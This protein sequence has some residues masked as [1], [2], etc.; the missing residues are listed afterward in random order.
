M[1]KLKS[2]LFAFTVIGISFGCISG[3]DKDP[4]RSVSA[5]NLVRIMDEASIEAQ[6]GCVKPI[7]LDTCSLY[8]TDRYATGR[9]IFFNAVT[10]S[11][12]TESPCVELSV[13]LARTLQYYPDFTGITPLAVQNKQLWLKYRSS[14]LNNKKQLQGDTHEK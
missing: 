2:T 4:I 14:K 8:F 13:K 6:Q 3:C 10:F 9:D 5:D 12:S 1:L 11:N 7:S